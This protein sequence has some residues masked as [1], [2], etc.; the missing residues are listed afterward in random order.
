[1]E[2]RGQAWRGEQVAAKV[3]SLVSLGLCHQYHCHR[4]SFVRWVPLPGHWEK[5]GDVPSAA[6]K[7]LSLCCQLSSLVSQK[8]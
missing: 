1:M 2:G 5:G 4:S 3:P 8:S 6:I 7:C